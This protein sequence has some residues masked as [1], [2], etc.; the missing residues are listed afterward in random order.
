MIS[1][2]NTYNKDELREY[3]ERTRKLLK[4]SDDC[5]YVVEP[6]IDGVA[7][8]LRYENGRLMLGCTRGDGITG[9]D[10]TANLRTIDSIPLV[11][12]GDAPAVL[13]VRGEAFFPSARFN[14]MNEQREEAGKEPFANPRNAAAGSLKQLDP[15]EV[16]KRPLDAVFYALGEVEGIE[17]DSHRALLEALPVFG[18]KSQPRVWHCTGLDEVEAA[19]DELEATKF[20]F[21]FEIDGA[22]IKVDDRN[23]YDML[24]STSKSPRWAT[25]FKYEPEQAETML[26]DI[27]I[28]VGRT[29]VLTPV[30]KLEPVQVSGTTVSRATLHNEEEIQRKDIRV[31]DRV[32]IEKKGEI[33]PAVVHVLTEKRSGKEKKF[34]MPKA[35]PV[36]GGNVSKREGEVAL[37][38]ENTT[39]PAQVKTFLQHFASRKAMDVEGLGSSLVEQLVDQGLVNDPVDLYH[40]KVEEVAG[41]ERMGRKS[42]QNLIDGL[43]ESK[44]R[45]LWRF[46]HALGIRHVGASTSKMLQQNF[47]NIEALAVA[48]RETLEALPDCGPIVAGSIHDFFRNPAV[49][50]RLQAFK[51]VG[52]DPQNE[53]TEE[54][55]GAEKPFA[56]QT[57]VITGTLGKYKRTEAGA[58][59]ERLGGKVSGSVSKNTS[60]LLAGEKAGSKL[61]RA[62][63]L[64]VRII[65]EDEFDAL[66]E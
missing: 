16:A 63:S 55:A 35:C 15:R 33:I 38:C 42:A 57:W 53:P 14:A 28:Q 1:L 18:F 48:D 40:L 62:E 23:L 54:T 5:T 64:G 27:T 22:V 8:S 21:E 49:I 44:G 19:V 10:I 59:V 4:Q 31:G 9:D 30:A 13:E 20:D 36:C 25:A 34:K 58:I 66:V 17:F 47:R 43:G 29:G 11:L 7:V 24:G 45:D 32:L 50:E 61:A 52:L 56:G 41:L 51:S 6:K 3:D 46:I 2:S 65:S 26:R 60:V 12:Q 37:R 39:C